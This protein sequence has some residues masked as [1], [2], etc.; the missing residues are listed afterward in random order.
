M[1]CCEDNHTALLV[2]SFRSRVS[3]GQQRRT[4]SCQHGPPPSARDWRLASLWAC[5]WKRDFST[6][7]SPPQKHLENKNR[8]DVKGCANIA[9]VNNQSSTAGLARPLDSAT[10]TIAFQSENG[11]YKEQFARRGI[12]HCGPRRAPCPIFPDRN[13]W[14]INHPDASIREGH[15]EA[16][17]PDVGG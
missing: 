4:G 11:I 12:Y 14:T 10:F 7:C 15:V 16:R 6:V 13:K 9:L 3:P 1:I 17:D 5:S 2:R 8:D